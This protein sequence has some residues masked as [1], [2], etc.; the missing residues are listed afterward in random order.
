LTFDG[1]ALS[2]FWLAD[3]VP[4]VIAV[5]RGRFPAIDHVTATLG[6][7]STVLAVPIPLDCSDGFG[8]A[9]YGRPEAF[10]DPDVRAAQSGWILTQPATVQRGVERLRID[11]QSGA[12][13]ER[14]GHLRQ[15]PQYVGAVRLIVANPD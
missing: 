15:T 11:L 7:R 3:Y 1:D 10:L 5:D 9:Y 6:G 12:W 4:D 14:H 13:D 2:D 8:E